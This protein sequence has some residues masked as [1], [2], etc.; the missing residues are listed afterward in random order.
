MSMRSRRVARQGLQ[1]TELPSP[2]N[3]ID[4]L[5]DR[6]GRNSENRDH[7]GGPLLG[8]GED[9]EYFTPVNLKWVVAPQLGTQLMGI[10]LFTNRFSNKIIFAPGVNL[11][12]ESVYSPMMARFD[13]LF[14][15]DVD[16]LGQIPKRGVERKWACTFRGKLNGVTRVQLRARISDDMQVLEDLLIHLPDTDYVLHL[17]EFNEPE[18]VRN[19][20]EPLEAVICNSR[21]LA[22][23]EPQIQYE[24]ELDR[25][26]TLNGDRDTAGRRAWRLITEELTRR[27]ANSVRAM[28]SVRNQV[29]L[30][31]FFYGKPEYKDFWEATP[32]EDPE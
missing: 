31:P 24:S 12:L 2:Y 25:T 6:R 20:F 29:A 8:A 17:D 21:F 27:S 18:N 26:V 10:S 32:D 28:N 16:R 23:E 30:S 15:V 9:P 7:D 5:F 1:R 22:R 19:H 4:H 3:A 13:E 14:L 11:A